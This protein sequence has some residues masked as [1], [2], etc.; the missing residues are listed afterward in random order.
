MN[1]S[2]RTAIK[3]RGLSKPLKV[4]LKNN[5]IEGN[6]VLDYGCG[7]GQDAETMKYDRYDPFY[8]P[9]GLDNRKRYDTI[10]CNYV[11][12]V[13][14]K[15]EEDKV[16]NDVLKRLTK[17]GKA[18]FTVRRDKFKEGINSK[19]TFQRTAKP[20]LESYYRLSGQFEIYILKK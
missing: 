5:A 16:I 20:N 6:R 17:N 11:L 14:S 9:E 3:R 13:I 12:N 4:L 1:K 18:Y 10:I 15:N 7:Y 8:Y 2:H 19:G